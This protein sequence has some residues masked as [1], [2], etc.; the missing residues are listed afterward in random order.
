MKAQSLL[1]TLSLLI[2]ILIK[3]TLADK[4]F[5]KDFQVKQINLNIQTLNNTHLITN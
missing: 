5:L 2:T 1:K 4:I 3:T